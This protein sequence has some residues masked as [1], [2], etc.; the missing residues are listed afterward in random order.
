[1]RL[2]LKH[3]PVVFTEVVGQRPRAVVL[4]QMVRKGQLPGALLFHGS[5]GCG[6]TTMARIL[7]MA[8]NCQAG[9]GPG[10]S[11]PCGTCPPCKSVI[12]GT[13]LDIIEIDGASHGSVEDMRDLQRRLQYGSGGEWR[14]VIIDEA[15]TVTGPGFESLLIIMENPP[16]GTVFV[17][18]TTEPR[19]IP[20]TI[21]S[22]CLPLP[23]PSVPPAEI[24]VRLEHICAAE[25]IEAE[26]ALLALITE[27]AEGNMRNAVMLLEQAHVT[28]I[29]TVA[30]W[31][32]LHGETDFAPSLLAAAADGDHAALYAALDV[33]LTQ[34]GD[35]PA[36]IE[37]LTACLR[38]LLVLGAGGT[39]PFT[40]QALAVRQDLAARASAARIV[41]ALK[42][43]WDLQT[44]VRVEDRKAGLILA[45][46]RVSDVLHPVQEIAAPS[47][48]T[49]GVEAPV[50]FGDMARMLSSQ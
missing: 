15:Q 20:A 13:S 2:A 50:A 30:D 41:S 46:A 11:W 1:M 37:K 39:I 44:K 12:A 22:R 25:H 33:V 40:G 24:T 8:L 14:L 42:V 3:R 21:A 35:Y 4:Y 17:L 38:D 23:F 18:C 26:A 45:L 43:L 49:S 29:A 48:G 32:R 5:S 28:G 34:T 6:K 7:G 31:Y 10:S 19:K 9:P 27:R 16:P 36:I 47:L